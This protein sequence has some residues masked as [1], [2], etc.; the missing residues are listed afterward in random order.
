MLNFNI[1]EYHIENL[2]NNRMS[3]YQKKSE[4]EIVE[5]IRS[6]KL[7][8]MFIKNDDKEKRIRAGYA[9]KKLNSILP[10]CRITNEKAFIFLDKK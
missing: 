5:I 8:G 9:L 2:I 7:S 6:I 1:I 3:E 10:P 4:D